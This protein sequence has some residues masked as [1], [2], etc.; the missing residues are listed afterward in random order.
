MAEEV[1]LRDGTPAVAWPLLATDRAALRDGFASLSPDSRYRRFLSGV[2][3]LSESALRVLVDAVDRPDPDD[4]TPGPVDHVAFVLVALPPDGEEEAVGVA[5]LVRY[6]ERPDT[7]DV[8]VTV[9]DAWQGRGAATALLRV[10]LGHRPPGTTRLVTQVATGNAASVAMLA[11][12]GR[13]TSRPA[14]SGVAEVTVE[15]P[16]DPAG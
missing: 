5:R 1:V 4:P 9:L 11:R 8:A 6:P 10:L 2:P 14:G 15:L 7:A 3:R 13:L 12:L 16:P